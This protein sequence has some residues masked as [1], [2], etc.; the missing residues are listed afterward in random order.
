MKDLNIKTYTLYLIE[1][2]VEKSLEHIGTG[3]NFLNRISMAHS[4]RSRI[5]KWTPSGWHQHQITLHP[6]SPQRTLHAI[7][8]SL[9][10][11]K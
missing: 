11:G 1:E 9:V 4:I 5:D 3:G 6:H 2:K 8:G 7:L 10:S